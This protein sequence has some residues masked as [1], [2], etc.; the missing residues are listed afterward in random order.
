MSALDQLPP[1]QRAAVSLV[2]RQGKSY[3]DVAALLR[4]DESAVSERAHAALS[5]LG[6]RDA[7]VDE[8]QRADIADF[9]LGQ[10]PA[11]RRAQ[12]RAMLERS[13]PA[14]A[15]AR[16]VSG[17]LR[18]LAAAAL[19]EIPS[20]AQE[21]DD[22]FEALK[23][24]AV[25]RERQVT[26]SRRGGALLLVGLGFVVA[27]AIL[28]I[29]G[30]FSSGSS[31]P[32]NAADSGTVTGSTTTTTTSTSSIS[33][34][35]HIDAQINFA[36]P[37]HTGHALAVANIISQGSQRAFALQAQGLAPTN[38]FAYA[39]W[40]YNSPTDA[41]ALGFINQKVTAN[42]KAQAI[43]PI[44]ANASHYRAIV[45][46]EETQSRPTKPGTIVLEGPLS[47]G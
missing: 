26:G 18:P 28:L 25:A 9:L 12:T 41:L 43:G 10:Q 37:N 33:A 15:W 23:Q 13:A 24:R 34:T 40:L 38:A 29:L 8:Q 19:P 16:V 47:L 3:A 21:V 27:A 2:L 11:S 17:E 39:V 5:V 7:A 20:E 30:V 46:T 35:P 42:G 45:I 31:T 32:K 6:P 36:P 1:D 44:P 4:I 14:R 22:A